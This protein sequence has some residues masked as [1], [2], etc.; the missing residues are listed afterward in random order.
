MKIG[1]ESKIFILA[2]AFVLIIPLA[3]A[4]Q[5]GFFEVKTLCINGDCRVVWPSDAS[6]AVTG[7]VAGGN[8]DVNSLVGHV[9]I[10][11]DDGNFLGFDQTVTGSWVFTL[12]E[13]TDI[14][15]TSGD[16]LSNSLVYHL[17]DLNFSELDGNKLWV[18]L[19]PNGV[20]QTIDN[21]NGLTLK[22]AT[23]PFLITEDTTNTVQNRIA[24][25]D[26][27]GLLGTASAH[28]VIF[29]TG[30]ASRAII[31]I[32]GNFGIGVFS[33]LIAKLQVNGDIQTTDLNV[34]SGNIKNNENTY[35]IDS[36]L[37]KNVL[38]ECSGDVNST[39]TSQGLCQDIT[40]FDTGGGTTDINGTDI[41]VNALNV[42]GAF[43][44]SQDFIPNSN[45]TQDIGTIALAMRNIFVDSSLSN[46]FTSVTVANIMNL[47]TVQTVTGNKLFADDVSLVFGTGSDANITFN[48][49][50]G[51]WEFDTGP[52]ITDVTF[53]QSQRSINFIVNGLET[54][55]FK[56]DGLNS[57]VGIRMLNP[58][59]TLDVNGNFKAD[60]INGIRA[61]LVDV[62]AIGAVFEDFNSNKGLI[63][64]SGKLCFRND[65]FCIFSPLTT[66]L[67]IDSDALLNLSIGGVT[68]LQ[69]NTD[70]RLTFTIIGINA[71]SLLPADSKLTFGFATSGDKMTLD[72][73][74]LNLEVDLNATKDVNVGETLAAEGE[75]IGGFDGFQAAES[76]PTLDSF[77]EFGDNVTPSSGKGYFPQCGGSVRS[78]GGTVD[79][80][81]AAGGGEITIRI[82]NGSATAASTTIDA[83]TTG[84][85]EFVVSIQRDQNK[86][87]QGRSMSFFI[88][89]TGSGTPVIDDVVLF[90][91][92]QLDC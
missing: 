80:G 23:V 88:A 50:I 92:L 70:G 19:N 59:T 73:D 51:R 6:S 35:S 46:G 52:A 74:S 31:D 1:K 22:D 86:F 14:N 28:P 54:N 68:K 21:S 77:V 24:S 78:L 2:I 83:T 57:R 62:N 17:A 65:D 91:R 29:Q 75:F 20:S 71:P 67:N 34:T 41:N 18:S 27:D 82:R 43:T 3:F 26:T 66:S 4:L 25:T 60:D 5:A 49:G 12:I 33:D 45:N 16:I 44:F 84:N 53:N 90:T 85:K 38:T 64:N 79:I 69:L 56:V 11:F 63:L 8:I 72:P 87:S 81:T 7:I 61:N 9:K 76:S 58:T 89:N 37:N 42:E 36:D 48:S 55:L 32:T 10:D 39:L 15:I 30:S 47:N 13:T 40:N